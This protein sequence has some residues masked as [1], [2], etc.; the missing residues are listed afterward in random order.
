M[1]YDNSYRGEARLTLYSIFLLVIFVSAFA[2]IVA[3]IVWRPW[4][5]DGKGAVVH[6]ESVPAAT[7][8]PASGDGT[9]P[10]TDQVGVPATP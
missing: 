1:Q 5:D 9:V 10:V 6:Q 8:D 2:L 3:A 7:A 4:F